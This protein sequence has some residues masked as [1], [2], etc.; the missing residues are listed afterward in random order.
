MKEQ[1]CFGD[2]PCPTAPV[3]GLPASQVWKEPEEP[4]GRA[5]GIWTLAIGIGI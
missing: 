2:G 5:L 1:H 3:W 4:L